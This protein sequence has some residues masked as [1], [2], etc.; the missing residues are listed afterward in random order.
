MRTLGA[1]WVCLTTIFSRGPVAFTVIIAQN[2]CFNAISCYGTWLGGIEV[3]VSRHKGTAIVG[4]ALIWALT[5]GTICLAG[6]RRGASA[7]DFPGLDDHG[8]IVPGLVRGKLPG[9]HIGI[10]AAQDIRPHDHDP[11]QDQ[12]GDHH[13]L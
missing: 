7:G 5:N 13:E 12:K 6:C 11:G 8:G 4:G 2:C 10:D 3:H 1:S 9:T